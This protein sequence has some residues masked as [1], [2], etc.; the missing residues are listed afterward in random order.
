MR[1]RAKGNAI[2]AVA[3]R[4]MSALLV[5]SL[6]GCPASA[7]KHT[8]A[9][10][11]LDL[12]MAQVLLREGRYVDAEKAYREFLKNDSKNP[13]AYDGLGVTLLSQGE[14]RGALAA[15]NEAAKL[16]PEKPLYRIHRGMAYTKLGQYKE[17]DGDFR[18]AES[19]TDPLDQLDLAVQLGKLRQQQG[20]FPAAE[21]FYAKALSRDPKNFEATLG[22]GVAREA[23]GRQ[24]AAAQDYLDAV[25]LRPKNADANLHL[26]LVLVTLH[27]EALGRRYLERTVDLDPGGDS[28]SRARLILESLG[29]A[30]RK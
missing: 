8:T 19:S 15:F 29:P 11:M 30:A 18:L 13:D 21:A 16:S 26:G 24:E 22:R 25:K 10:A 7:K 5:L 20:D 9:E 12:R 6:T 23:Q 14:N 27:R 3:G 4:V 28:A 1:A 17:A 2:V